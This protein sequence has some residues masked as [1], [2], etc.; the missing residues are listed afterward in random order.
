MVT[1]I[2]NLAIIG[3]NIPDSLFEWNGSM[4]FYCSCQITEFVQSDYIIE[5]NRQ[6]Q[7]KDC[8]QSG[9]KKFPI[10]GLYHKY[11]ILCR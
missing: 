9:A 7:T 3:S 10:F 6:S 5:R 8:L 11:S 2:R 4:Q 1:K